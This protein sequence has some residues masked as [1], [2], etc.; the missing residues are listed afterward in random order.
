MEVGE[1]AVIR[2]RFVTTAD[3]LKFWNGPV[4]L[5]PKEIDVLGALLDS[6]GDLCG[7]ENRRQASAALGM[8][9]EVLNT[10]LT[11]LKKKKAISK[12]KGVHHL[13][14]IF[15]ERTHVEVIMHR[16]ERK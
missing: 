4:G 10:Y 9:P 5:S 1:K 12:V 13:I 11:R 2:V 16:N 15:V 14:P 6:E 3:R 8:N 7:E